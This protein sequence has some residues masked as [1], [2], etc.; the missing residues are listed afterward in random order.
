MFSLGLSNAKY[1]FDFFKNLLLDDTSLPLEQ[2]FN[3]DSLVVKHG[4]I[5]GALKDVQHQEKFQFVR[6][7]YFNCYFDKENNNHYVFNEI[8]ALKSSYKK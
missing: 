1:L 5:E 2:R 7:G 8:V 3:K 4:V 6:N